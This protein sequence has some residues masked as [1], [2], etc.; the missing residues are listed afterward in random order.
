MDFDIDTGSIE[1]C[2][3]AKHAVILETTCTRI[4]GV[5]FG[6]ASHRTWVEKVID[7]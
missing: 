5:G 4:P 2:L 3:F 6:K 1:K 7:L